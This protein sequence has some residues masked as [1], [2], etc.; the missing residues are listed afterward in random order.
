[1]RKLALVMVMYSPALAFF[2]FEAEDAGTLGG[3]GNFQFETN[4]ASFKYYNGARRQSLDFQFQ[5]GLLKNM[6]LALLQPY[7][8]LRE[9]GER[10]SGLDDLRVFIKHIPYEKEGWRAGYRLQLNLDT[11]KRGIGYGKTTANLN[12]ILERDIGRLTLNLN[13]VYLKSSHVEGLR[14]A[15][16]VI[17][18]AYGRPTQWLT[19]GAELKYIRPEQR[20]SKR[21]THA[22]LG[23]LL[24]PTESI[25]LSFGLHK[26]LNKHPAQPDYGFLAGFLY[27]F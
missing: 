23:I 6:D 27:R 18:H 3:L 26:S 1:M 19:L 2:P 20:E 5:A 22:L 15:Y 12:L 16:G 14:D 10:L 24:H 17:F 13:G 21:D 8:K 25:D 9:W 7:V 11:G 4:Y